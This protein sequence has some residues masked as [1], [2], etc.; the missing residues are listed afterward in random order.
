M[1]VQFVSEKYPPAAG[2]AEKSIHNLLLYLN[3]KGFE[4]SIATKHK[5]KRK[6]WKSPLKPSIVEISDIKE[7]ENKILAFQPDVIFTQI[8]WKN[9]VISLARKHKIPSVFFSRV[10]DINFNADLIVFNSKSV[11]NRWTKKYPYIKSFSTVLYPTINKDD[12]CEIP[13]IN[14]DK[15]LCI[16]PVRAK[17]GKLIRKIALALPD[18]K[19]LA[20]IGWCHP[21]SDGVDLRSIKN[22]EIIKPIKFQKL[23]NRS[24]LLLMPSVWPEPF[25]RVIVEA[26]SCGLPVIAT[27][28]GGI[29]EAM[30]GA[31]I[32]INKKADPKVW[33]EKIIKLYRDKNFYQKHRIK[34]LKRAKL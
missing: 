6:N 1:K 25:G 20:T 3:N 2:G 18:F 26:M 5:S 22:I 29:P 12:M 31:G 10:E 9:E 24:Y 17:G 28:V 8:D 27:K 19:F 21:N 7:I 33:T 34:S 11:R 30:G 15:I 23:C 32:L 16:N 13:T 14:G 4:I